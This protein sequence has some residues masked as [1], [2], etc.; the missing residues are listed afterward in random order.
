MLFRSVPVSPDSS[1]DI[2][3]VV[4]G[5]DGEPRPLIQSAEFD[6]SPRV[7]P[8]G[9]WLAYVSVD[10]GQPEVY[11]RPFPDV[12]GG[13]WTVSSDGGREPRWRQDGKELFYQSLDQQMMAVAVETV[14]TF[15]PSVPNAL[16]SG[17]YYWSLG[18]HTYDVAPDGRFL[19]MRNVSEGA[20]IHVV[21][22]WLDELIERVPTS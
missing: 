22:N 6:Y 8:D 10:S 5:S 13:L 12:D 3:L 2:A 20:S 15:A 1:G 21:L 19:M 18:R 4:P 17:D 7:S 11:V 9:E 16:F 14:P